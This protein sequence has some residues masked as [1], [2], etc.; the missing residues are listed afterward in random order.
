M[1]KFFADADDFF[2]SSEEESDFD[3]EPEIPQ[4]DHFSSDDETEEEAA[5]PEPV[6]APTTG[7]GRRWLREGLSSDDET[8][9]K[10]TVRSQKDKLYDQLEGTIKK[11]RNHMKINDWVSLHT[12]KIKFAQIG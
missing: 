10:R 3:D 11:M 7:T 1:P 5:E 2:S 8:E 6:R 4:Q 12:G 9:Q